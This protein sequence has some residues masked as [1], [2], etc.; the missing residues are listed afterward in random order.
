MPL[1]LTVQIT[2]ATSTLK[3]SIPQTPSMNASDLG[4]RS[5]SSISEGEIPEQH[6]PITFF[7]DGSNLLSVLILTHKLQV[8][9]GHLNVARAT[10][11]LDF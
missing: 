3:E 8:A 2:S 11:K 6:C 9:I 4:W 7:E 5:R 10:E 1:Q